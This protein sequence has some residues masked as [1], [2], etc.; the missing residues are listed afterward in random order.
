LRE[1]CVMFHC[2]VWKRSVADARRRE[3]SRLSARREERRMRRRRKAV[4]RNWM[5]PRTRSGENGSRR[6]SD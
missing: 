3:N 5:T 4:E 2:Y 1:Q 6:D